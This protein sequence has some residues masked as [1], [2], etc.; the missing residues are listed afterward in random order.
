MVSPPP[1]ELARGIDR[2]F[3]EGRKLWWSPEWEA[4]RRLLPACGTE[5]SLLL[6]PWRAARR[7]G[8]G[9]PP[10]AGPDVGARVIENEALWEGEG[11][12]LTPNRYPFTEDHL[13]LWEKRPVREPGPEFLELLLGL[14]RERKDILAF[15]NSIGAAATVSRAHAQLAR[16]GE[17]PP[18]SRAPVQAVDRDGLEWA[19]PPQGGPWPGFFA[20]LRGEPAP[21]A[22]ALARLVRLRLCPAFNLSVHGDSA[23]IFFRRKE[24]ARR[25]YPLP[26]GALEL[27]G[28]FLFEAEPSFHVMTPEK[29][30]TALR[31]TT[32]PPGPASEKAVLSL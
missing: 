26:V 24:T 22:R 29:V 28:I 18:V 21:V 11:A 1:R 17:P 14:C 15:V 31:E 6:T 12:V 13:L 7:P 32:F 5:I 23:W 19:F 8:G 30:E 16:T 2:F 27:S 20:R 3:R 10:P 4:R 25:A 9:T